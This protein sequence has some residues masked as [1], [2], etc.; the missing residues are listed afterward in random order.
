ME[1]PES[2]VPYVSMVNIYSTRGK[3]KERARTIKRMKEIGVSNGISWI[4]IEKKVHSFVVQD[5][6][7]PQTEAI[8]GVLEELLELMLDE[9]Y[10]P[11][12]VTLTRV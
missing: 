5:R 11:G 2:S 3:W 12:Y 6:M 9:G 4:E 1:T 8:Y 7:H 10:V